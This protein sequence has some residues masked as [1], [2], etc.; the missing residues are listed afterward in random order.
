MNKSTK[1]R[2]DFEGQFQSNISTKTDQDNNS[3]HIEKVTRLSRVNPISPS[4]SMV[5]SR[6]GSPSSILEM[7]NRL[8]YSK[9]L[10][11][12]DY[13]RPE[14]ILRGQN[15]NPSLKLNNS[16]ASGNFWPER[17]DNFEILGKPQLKK[18]INLENLNSSKLT[19]LKAHTTQKTKKFKF[20]E[21]Y[22]LN[23]TAKF[24]FDNSAQ[25]ITFRPQVRNSKENS[26]N[27][28]E[29]FH[30]NNNNKYF[31]SIPE[32]QQKDLSLK[33][34]NLIQQM[35]PPETVNNNLNYS[36]RV[37]FNIKLNTLNFSNPKPKVSTNRMLNPLFNKSL[38]TQKI[39]EKEDFNESSGVSYMPL[40][41]SL[42]KS[43]FKMKEMYGET[44]QESENNILTNIDEQLSVLLNNFQEDLEED[45]DVSLQDQKI[46][47]LML[48]FLYD[49]DIDNSNLNQLNQLNK[50]SFRKFITDRYFRDEVKRDND[51]GTLYHDVSVH[52][53]SGLSRSDD[54]SSTNP[55]PT[56]DTKTGLKSV[57]IL[58]RKHRTDIL[59]IVSPNFIEQFSKTRVDKKLYCIMS[60]INKECLND[61]NVDISV[62]QDYLRK[63]ERLNLICRRKKKMH[64]KTKRNDEKIKKI[65]KRAMKSLFKDFKQKRRHEAL[66]NIELEREFYKY[67]FGHLNQQIELFFDPL[68]KKL[69]NPCFKSISSKYL[70]FLS[71]SKKFVDYLRRY[72]NEKMILDVLKKYPQQLIKKFKENPQFLT[73]MDK[74]KTK[75]EWIKHEL[76]AAIYHFLFIFEQCRNKTSSE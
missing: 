51:I 3:K 45:D 19:L 32:I 23:K 60:Q 75:F 69:A 46:L 2:F 34:K 68:K 55:K 5:S 9:L 30:F 70:S 50:K 74:F 62:F 33:N 67:Y 73:E 71:Q 8:T 12:R 57:K 29:K 15:I 41:N 1:H 6:H 10:G 44:I 20:Q 28:S 58:I 13:S 59:K 18:K 61:L 14:F 54:E 26:L 53:N 11:K 65:F 27:N 25:R 76:R 17:Y 37:N 63:R 47:V 38:Q 7:H 39:S 36:N 16:N 42:N 48:K 43:N 40:K 24:P 64:K 21:H 35:Q 22:N 66:N 4:F 31:P 52:S 72:C 56:Q 49:L